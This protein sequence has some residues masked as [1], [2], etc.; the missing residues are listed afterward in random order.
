MEV[1]FSYLGV[2]GSP[3]GG[4]PHLQVAEGL[5]LGVSKVT[6]CWVRKL[7]MIEEPQLKIQT[8]CGSSD[9]G[10]I[11]HLRVNTWGQTGHQMTCWFSQYCWTNLQ[12]ITGAEPQI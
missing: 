5:C 6:I 9:T 7:F 8:D 1:I 3:A 2:N 11:L 10:V 4:E 12:E